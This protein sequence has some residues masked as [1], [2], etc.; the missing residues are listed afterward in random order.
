M[1]KINPNP[2]SRRACLKAGA[3]RKIAKLALAGALGL[4][5]CQKLPETVPLEKTP[6]GLLSPEKASEK[7]PGL[8]KARLSTTK[9]DFVIEIHRDWAPQGADRFYN[10]VRLGF[11]DDT[12]FFRV[13]DGFMAQIGIHGSP[14]VM[15]KWRDA[16]I[17]DDP[18]AGQSNKR[19][20]VT[21]ATAGPNS[22]TTQF[23]IN[24]GDNSNLDAMGFPPFGKI[25]QGMDVVANLYNGYGD[26]P[27]SG[28]VG[29]DQGRLQMEGNAYLR[30]EYPKLDYVK[31]ARIEK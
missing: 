2:L 3:S 31:T 11:Y 17:P 24:F 26:S 4:A 25:A 10:L 28:G 12:A 7:A 30:K 21:Y 13:V 16:V 15:A 18:A 19:G 14:P 29:P 23:F 9:G 6:P 22:R 20:Y 5:A 27:A 1:N 8:F